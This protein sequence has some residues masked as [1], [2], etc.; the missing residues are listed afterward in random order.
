[1]EVVG[2]ASAAINTLAMAGGGRGCGAEDD[3]TSQ[4]FE[5]MSEHS[6][7]I[8]VAQGRMCITYFNCKG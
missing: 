4:N 6:P 2:V 5:D 1:V 3:Q 8:H 7:W